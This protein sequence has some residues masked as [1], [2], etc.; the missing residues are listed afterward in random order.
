[1]INIIQQ[2]LQTNND[3]DKRRRSADKNTRDMSTR[4]SCNS[5]AYALEL[6]EDP[7]D[8][9]TIWRDLS[10]MLGRYWS[11]CDLHARQVQIL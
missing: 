5:K 10:I 1:M 8:M 6:Q 4:F 9:F 3:D 7:V 2:V 11:T